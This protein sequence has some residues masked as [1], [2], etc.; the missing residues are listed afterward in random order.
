MWV[1]HECTY[2][3]KFNIHF[4]QFIAYY[5]KTIGFITVI[6][7]YILQPVKNTN[8]I[9]VPMHGCYLSECL[10]NENTR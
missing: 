3:P 10:P 6:G 1:P 7:N 2:L 5:L 4:Y 8:Y 9:I